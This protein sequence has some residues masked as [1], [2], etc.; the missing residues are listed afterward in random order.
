MNNW[1]APAILIVCLAFVQTQT[2]VAQ[3][4]VPD[5]SKMSESEINKLPKEVLKRL[6]MKVVMARLTEGKMAGQLFNFMLTLPLSRLMYFGPFS[7]TEIEAATK[8]FQADL[9]QSATGQL[10]MGQFEELQRRWNR[11]ND[12]RVYLP[13][14]GDELSI[15]RVGKDYVSVEGTWILED[16][17]IA[18]PINQSKITCYKIERSCEDIQVELIV[19]RFDEGGDSYQINISK[20]TTEIISW[21]DTEVITR[22]EGDCRTSILTINSTTKEVYEVTRNNETEL[23]SKGLNSLFKIP[24]LKKPRI[25][26]LVPGWKISYKFWQ[27]RQSR[28]SKFLNSEVQDMVK[29][30]T[31]DLKSK[32]A[33]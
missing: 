33:K 9:G 23:C 12:T 4:H 11:S 18:F 1:L 14:F 21:S 20:R 32:M 31:K 29:A 15:V 13:T 8:K 26:R 5:V 3:E 30:M 22:D 2:S 6:P 7:E 19:P 24:P 17:K 28:A 27:D 10:T 25:A 16:E